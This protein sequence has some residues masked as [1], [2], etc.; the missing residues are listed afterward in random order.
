V[1]VSGSSGKISIAASYVPPG[2]NS[3]LYQAHLDNIFN[4][5]ASFEDSDGI[6]AAGDFNLSSVFWTWNPQASAMVPGNLH[7]SHEII[8]INDCFSMGLTQI[9][10]IFNDL[11]KLLDLIFK[12]ILFILTLL[13]L[14]L[15][16]QV[17]LY[18][19]NPFA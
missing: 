2:S 3:V 4:I 8:V 13:L 9:N 18:I 5:H 1:K 7:Q 6:C 17:G 15:R 10:K 16:F 12:I 19:T 11:Q 14:I